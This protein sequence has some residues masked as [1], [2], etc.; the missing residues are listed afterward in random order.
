MLILENIRVYSIMWPPYVEDQPHIT[1]VLSIALGAHLGI[2][3]IWPLPV[4]VDR[5]RDHCAT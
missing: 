2:G 1:P 5:S 4:L 3:G